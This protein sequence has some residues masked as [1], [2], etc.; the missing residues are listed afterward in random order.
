MSNQ[1]KIIAF[2]VNN[3]SD[4]S[5]FSQQERE[6]LPPQS[7]S[8][9]NAE[10]ET[11]EQDRKR[12]KH[13]DRSVGANFHA[14]KPHYSLG[15]ALAKKGECEKAIYSYRKALDI[16]SNSAEIYQ[17]LGDTLVKTGELDEAVIVYHKAIEL[18]PNLWEVHHNLGDIWQG[19]GRLDEA[20]V[21][22]RLAI[23][24]N[25]NFCW[26][27]NN[28]G[29]VLIKQEKWEE[30]V[31]GYRSATRLNPDFHWS[32]YN[33][34]EALVELERW[35]EAI[36]AYR[37]AIQLKA[38]L[39]LVHEK[40]GEALQNQSR[41]YAEEAISWYRQAIE[42]NPDDLELYHK[43]LEIKPDDAEL[44]LGLG[45]ALAR[46]GERDEAIVFYRMGLQVKPNHLKLLLELGLAVQSN[47][48]TQAINLYHRSLDL[49]PEAYLANL[50]LGNAL[51]AA[52]KCSEAMAY[53]YK[54]IDLEP[55]VAEAYCQLGNALSTQENWDEAL[56]YYRISLDLEPNC[57]EFQKRLALAILQHQT[58]EE[59]MAK[60]VYKWYKDDEPEVSI[61]ILN[62]HKSHLTID[63]LKSLWSHTTGF[64]YE[65]IVVDNGSSPSDFHQ[66]AKFPGKFKLIRL[67]AN[68]FFGEGNNIGFE[69][70]QG[71]YAVFM[72]ND[73]VVTENWLSPLMEVLANYPD[74]GCVG[75]KFVYPNGKLQEA[76]ALLNADGSVIQ[77]GK[78]QDPNAPEFNELRSVDFC[79]AATI[80]MRRE[81]FEQ[82][83]GFDLCWEPAYYEDCDLCLKIEL[84]GLKTYYCPYSKVIHRENG[85]SSDSSLGLKLNNIVEINKTK[86]LNRW[87]KYLSSDRS[88][89]TS[90][91]SL[92]NRAEKLTKTLP[93]KT[94]NSK[95]V[96]LYTP[97]NLIPG[98][99]ERYLLSIAETF[100]KDN[101]VYLITPEKFSHLRLLTLGRDLNLNLDNLRLCP[102]YE[103][104]QIP[105]IDLFVAMGNEIAPPIQTFGRRNIFV[106]QFPFPISSPELAR[107]WSWLQG[108]E[109]LV[110][111]SMFARHFVCHY[112]NELQLPQRPVDIV[113]PPVE[114]MELDINRTV[115]PAKENIILN[116]G[117]F[118]TGAHCKR[119]DIMIEVF[120]TILKNSNIKAE[121][122][123]VGSLHPE[124]EHRDY[125]L[126]LKELARGLPVF[127]H[128]NASPEFLQSIYDRASIYWHATGIDINPSTDPEKCEHF[129]ITPV[130]AMSAGCIPI[131][132][133]K[134]GL[135]EI[136]AHEHSGFCFETEQQ[137]Q[138]ITTH[139]LTEKNMPWVMSMREAAVE[140]SYEYSKA[141]F[142]QRWQEFLKD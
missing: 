138:E 25:P 69:H 6:L 58:W 57:L 67:E 142:A 64:T 99:G 103:L 39:P 134:G 115:I 81:I 129:G 52:N 104:N 137:L 47:D 61:I 68:R 75:S 118:F 74:A 14:A 29:D 33:L 49:N 133:N 124:P 2:P 76:G 117:R 43:A 90:L 37:S 45:N 27:H 36:G 41:F 102:L 140:K 96:C 83:M 19:Q 97:Y 93:H 38:D 50:Y 21:A 112:I 16:D 30:A 127:F 95:V 108:Y 18:Q 141:A 111:Y 34:G 79:S 63:C 17:S 8:L 139:I 91:L 121:L 53:Y 122:H 126:R 110:V 22:Y 42:Q 131:V 72:N 109:R 100:L 9:K 80:L 13:Y 120:R 65:I 46:Q 89:Q 136:V 60:R 114:L 119:Q 125:F 132:V 101:E 92:T 51:A 15:K 11:G 107:R 130:E 1:S 5:A 106:C 82:V 26:S 88:E 12:N 62:F 98:G 3:H 78:Y 71:K 7:V 87:S 116:V 35:E 94:N 55:D 32:Y 44:Y 4:L 56:K 20:V 54:A 84:L 128:L 105:Q 73:I 48:L 28:L 113:H 77:L 86:F 10:S 40:L 24:L 31:E 23:E 66:L 70:S 85:T 123:L 59:I 135:P